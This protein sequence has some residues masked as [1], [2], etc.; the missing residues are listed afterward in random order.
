MSFDSPIL[1][2]FCHPLRFTS[3]NN[4]KRVCI[5]FNKKLAVSIGLPSRPVDL[6]LEDLSK[7]TLD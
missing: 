7:Q 6:R 1:C 3:F 2:F 5:I 4:E